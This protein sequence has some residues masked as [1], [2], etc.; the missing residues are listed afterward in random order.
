MLRNWSEVIP[1]TGPA[2]GFLV[3]GTE[4][5]GILGSDILNEMIDKYLIGGFY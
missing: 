4:F 3:S 2:A 5:V 1:G